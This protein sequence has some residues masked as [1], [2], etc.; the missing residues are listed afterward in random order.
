[1]DEPLK[2]YIE[3]AIVKKAGLT[4]VFAAIA[5]PMMVYAAGTDMKEGLWEIAVTTEMSGMPA[6]MPFGGQEIKQTH[7]YTQKELKDS[8][9]TLPKSDEKCEIVDYKSSGKKASW[10]VQCKGENAMNGSG[11][12]LYKGDSYESTVKMTSK[13]SRGRS[14]Q[15]IQHIKGRRLGNCK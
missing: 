9:N 1:M 7:C 15:I 12:I 14:M 13:N 8:K 3:E 2:K 4:L 11:E 6:G 5:F 10:A